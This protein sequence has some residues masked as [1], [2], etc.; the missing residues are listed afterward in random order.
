MGLCQLMPYKDPSGRSIIFMDSSRQD[1]KNLTI[2]SQ[3]RAAAYTI[4]VALEEESTQQ[5]GIVII[6]WPYKERWDQP[7]RQFLSL[8]A[9]SVKGALPVRLSAIHVCQHK[10]IFN[11]LIP[12]VKFFMGERLRKRLRFH[13][14]SNDQVRTALAPY[15]LTKNV[16]PTELG[17]D[18][19]L[20][21]EKWLAARKQAGK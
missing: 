21:Q 6:F 17:G 11:L 1:H 10:P 3:A 2:Q 9:S 19:E 4:M 20:Q 15:G 7:N 8:L 13:S 12:L 18:V 14:G 5:R 16:L